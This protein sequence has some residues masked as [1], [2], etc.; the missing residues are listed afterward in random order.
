MSFQFNLLW[1]LAIFFL[2]KKHLYDGTNSKHSGLLFWFSN[3]S[4]NFCNFVNFFILSLLSYIRIHFLSLRAVV[5]I[6][7]LPL[8]TA[9]VMSCSTCV[10]VL[11]K[12]TIVSPQI[13]PFKLKNLRLILMSEFIALS[14]LH[15]LSRTTG[16][17]FCYC[18]SS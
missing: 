1:F 5:D 18:L 15:F 16:V 13:S 12:Q 8:I 7:L 11:F 2:N 4:H 6:L 10:R 9:E 3:A 14:R 17:I